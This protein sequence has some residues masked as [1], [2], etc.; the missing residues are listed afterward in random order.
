MRRKGVL[1]QSRH[2]CRADSECSPRLARGRPLL[3][4]A[5]PASVCCWIRTWCGECNLTSVR[6]TQQGGALVDHD[7]LP[8]QRAQGCA[9]RG[10]GRS[11]GRLGRGRHQ[12]LSLQERASGRLRRWQEQHGQDG[13]CQQQA[14]A[15][16]ARSHG[17]GGCGLQCVG[18]GRPHARPSIIC[19]Q[20]RSAAWVA[21][22]GRRASVACGSPAPHPPAY[23]FP[24]PAPC[25]TAGVRPRAHFRHVPFM[26]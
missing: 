17:V 16:R 22:Q 5:H 2:E 15:T 9:R 6:H 10:G 4:Q 7:L 20:E 11:E 3:Q 21:A 26:G 23:F 24:L 12:I 18:R 13:S 19:G 14:G 1:W 8:C 25:G